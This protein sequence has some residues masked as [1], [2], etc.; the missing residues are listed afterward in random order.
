MV[1][2]EVCV[3]SACHLRGSYNVINAFK[4]IIDKRK[5]NDKVEIKAAFCL[6][7]C[8][9]PVSVRVDEGEVQSVNEDNV[10]RFFDENVM[11]RL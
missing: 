6:G 11:K 10:E 3:G 8:T 2:I 9:R 7:N 5:L 4:E 1:T